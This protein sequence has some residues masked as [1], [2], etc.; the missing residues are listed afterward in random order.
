VIYENGSEFWEPKWGENRVMT[1][2]KN[3]I[4]ELFDSGNQIILTTSRPE[5]FREKTIEQLNRDEISYHQLVMGVFHGT[6][7]LINDYSDTNPYPVAKA[8]NT[9]R[10]TCDF[11]DM[12]D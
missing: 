1:E 12:I 11:V 10:N 3:K 4:N 5:K 8:I 2:A 6:R 9:K 7:Y